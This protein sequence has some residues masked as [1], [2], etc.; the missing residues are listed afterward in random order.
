MSCND[1]VEILKTILFSAVLRSEGRPERMEF[2]HRVKAAFPE[3]VKFVAFNTSDKAEAE[4]T[5][6][7]ANFGLK[8]QAQKHNRLILAFIN[9]LNK[10]EPDYVYLWNQF[11]ALHRT[12][13]AILKRR[14]IPM[15][16]FH[17][18][19]LAGS[20]A[21]DVDAEMGESWISQ[22]PERFM[23]VGVDDEQLARAKQFLEAQAGV[24]NN[25]HPQEEHVAVQEALQ[26]AGLGDRPLVFYAGQNDWH[27]GIKPKSPSRM[28]HSPF[29]EGTMEALRVLDDMAGELGFAV[30]F[31]PHPLSRDRF[32]F[33]HARDYPN[34]VILQ[35]T[36]INVCLAVSDIV[37]TIASQAGYV[38]LQED[39]SVMMLG[40]NQ[41]TGKGLT[42]DVQS[43]DTLK[44]TILEALD[45]PL[46]SVRQERFAVHA[47]QL[48]RAYL[49]DYGTMDTEFYTRGAVE[50]AR[51][52]NMCVTHSSE[53]VIAA[54]VANEL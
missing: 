16:F 5:V 3:P 42:Y 27:A 15:G 35:H 11:N 22:D 45:D 50:A 32:A 52:M 54:L 39:C 44:D 51:L 2:L 14:G 53:D 13:E 34:T 21:L 12:F 47:A 40:R 6:I 49:F 25:R 28:F 10:E 30:L 7:N 4:F 23:S 38:G 8:P 17:D 20:I 46:K 26:L 37:S 29:Y 43:H 41:V 33:L 36:S 19:V 24:E 31:K 18:G 48:E 1:E 9:A